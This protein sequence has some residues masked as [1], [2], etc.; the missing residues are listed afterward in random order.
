M[1]RTQVLARTT[2]VSEIDNLE[3]DDYLNEKWEQKAERAR[4]KSY[5]Q[6]RRQES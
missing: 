2:P 3:T 4:L 6:A 5:R 1:R